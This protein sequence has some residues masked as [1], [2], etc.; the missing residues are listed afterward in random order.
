MYQQMAYVYDRL[1]GEEVI[2]EWF[3][4]IKKSLG[5]TAPLGNKVILDVG[6]GTGS[7]AIRLAQEG[8]RLIGLDLSEDMLTVAREK[9]EQAKAEVLWIQQDMTEIE[10]SSPVD[11]V[12]CLCDSLNYLLSEESVKHTFQRVS[13]ALKPEGLFLFDVHTP[14]KIV[15][16]FGRQTFAYEDEE[17]AYIW[18][19]DSNEK[20][21]EVTNDLTFFIRQKGTDSSSSAVSA[22]L[23]ARFNELHQERAYPIERLERWLIDA[24]MK[25]L[26]ITSDF[27]QAD[28]EA[29]TERA[30][31]VAQKCR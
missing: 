29:D 16:G 14:Y 28:L 17:M 18:H 31:F 26:S 2:E 6:C 27:G 21:L 13:A 22:E 30:F 25:V 8:Y 5:H 4:W 23:Y 24:G 12:L 3:Q 11:Y 9:M 15:E 10:L 1:M 20:T 19:S 7:I